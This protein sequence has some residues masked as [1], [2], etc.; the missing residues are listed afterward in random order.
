[1]NEIMRGKY[2]FSGPKAEQSVKYFDTVLS[3]GYRGDM[4]WLAWDAAHKFCTSLMF[5]GAFAFGDGLIYGERGEEAFE[6]IREEYRK[7]YEVCEEFGRRKKMISKKAEIY[8]RAEELFGV[9]IR[10]RGVDGYV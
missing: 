4:D 1:M 9:K 7:A 6:Y 10:R 5:D 8:C 3:R 2:C